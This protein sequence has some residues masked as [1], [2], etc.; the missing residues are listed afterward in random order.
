MVFCNKREHLLMI[1]PFKQTTFL[2]SVAEVKQLPPDYGN[3]VAFVG[4]S[5]A[6][7]SSA[8]NTITGIKNLARTSKTPGR[9]QLINFFK[10]DDNTRLVDLPGYGYAKAAKTTSHRWQELINSYLENR[11]CLRGIVLIMDIRHPLKELDNYIIQWAIDY[12]LPVHILLTKVDKLTRNEAAK[13]LHKVEKHIESNT[14][15]SIQTF[16]SLN[17]IGLDSAR[18]KITSLLNNLNSM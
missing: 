13:T 12:H 1:N 15:V 9:T 4:Y 11:R 18:N 2:L 8:I 3:E 14:L 5:N 7:K 17:H 6:G 10:L 16:S